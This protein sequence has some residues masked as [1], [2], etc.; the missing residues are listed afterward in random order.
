MN[1]TFTGE[2]DDHIVIPEAIRDVFLPAMR[3]DQRRLAVALQLQRLDLMQQMLHRIRGALMIVTAQHLADTARLIEE[4]IAKEAAPEDCLQFTAR[5]L[6]A[7]DSA[8]TGLESAESQRPD[9]YF[10]QPPA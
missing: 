5:F 9:A 7:L 1:L 10:P 8:L 4:A 3:S 2:R 6:A